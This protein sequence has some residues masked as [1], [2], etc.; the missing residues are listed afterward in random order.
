[1]S[2]LLDLESAARKSNDT[3][4]PRMPKRLPKVAITAL[5]YDTGDLEITVEEKA[6]T[7]TSDPAI[8]EKTIS[9][10]KK[11]LKLTSTSVANKGETPIIT[12][13]RA[14]LKLNLAWERKANETKK[15]KVGTENPRGVSSNEARAVIST[16][17]KASRSLRKEGVH[18]GEFKNLKSASHTQSACVSAVYLLHEIADVGW[19]EAQDVFGIAKAYYPLGSGE[20]MTGAYGAGVVRVEKT[21]KGLVLLPFVGHEG[22]A[23][24]D[25]D[26][27]INFFTTDEKTG[28]SLI[29]EYP[30]VFGK[31]S[32]YVKMYDVFAAMSQSLARAGVDINKITL[33]GFFKKFIVVPHI[34]HP[35]MTEKELTNL[36]EHFMHMDKDLEK[37]ILG[38]IGQ[39]IDSSPRE[40]TK[41]QEYRDKF[42]FDPER[43]P[44]VDGLGSQRTSF[45]FLAD[46]AGLV[47]TLEQAK[48]SFSITN[49]EN[50]ARIEDRF[51]MGD[52]ARALLEEMDSFR[53]EFGISARKLP[54]L[55]KLFIRA[56]N[57]L[58]EISNS[59]GPLEDIIGAFAEIYEEKKDSQALINR[60]MEN[61]RY[62]GQLLR[63]TQTYKETEKAAHIQEV[64][65][66]AR[67]TGN[68]YPG[69]ALLSLISTVAFVP[70][71]ELVSKVILLVG[72]GSG[73][74]SY[75]L[76]LLPND[77]A[78]IRD[79]QLRLRRM[80]EYDRRHKIP[81]TKEEYEKARM[82]KDTKDFVRIKP[83]IRDI[84]PG[85]NVPDVDRKAIA[86][87]AREFGM[88]VNATTNSEALRSHEKEQLIVV[89][90]QGATRELTGQKIRERTRS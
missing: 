44:Y 3:A 52:L 2:G 37:K 90:R 23:R 6:R 45:R 72:Y 49:R 22:G 83:M 62:F 11:G 26:K 18:V 32:E 70:A 80:I 34:P 16:Y 55:H 41:V 12:G 81:I 14:E 19:T 48:K 46:V 56:E 78:T 35:Q 89:A 25:F 4:L 60:Y 67:I 9:T 82:E 77:L 54:E 29:S 53:E 51:N 31:Y 50:G 84:I 43:I 79:M 10:A 40:K 58:A 1:M 24:P 65:H 61:D 57:R 27:L 38:E 13:V 39:F 88:F 5:A 75:S 21:G 63:N 15:V 66:L 86:A 20:D 71:E 69:S 64:T 36:I 76:M 28:V 17:N 68:T 7:I 74:E 33:D 73:D 30:I 59:G 8:L 47:L 87:F 42:G 85:F